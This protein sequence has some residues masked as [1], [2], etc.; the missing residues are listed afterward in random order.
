MVRNNAYLMA[1]S[2]LSCPGEVIPN[3][4][5]LVPRMGSVGGTAGGRTPRA[6]APNERDTCPDIRQFEKLKPDRA[7]AP[8]PP[9][10][11]SRWNLIARRTYDHIREKAI[12]RRVGNILAGVFQYC[13]Q[14]PKSDPPL[15]RAPARL[16]SSVGSRPFLRYP[17]MFDPLTL[18][19]RFPPRSVRRKIPPLVLQIETSE[20]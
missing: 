17:A 6:K 5:P 14:R 19:S 13:D 20:T 12:W 8:N 16:P 3:P 2:R 7:L 10:H 15:R 4:H 18:I 11:I 1:I 9:L